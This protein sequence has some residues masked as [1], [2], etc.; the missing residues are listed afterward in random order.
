MDIF[1]EFYGRI[2]E[3]HTTV[4][5][6]V[7]IIENLIEDLKNHE[8]FKSETNEF[9]RFSDGGDIDTDAGFNDPAPSNSGKISKKYFYQILLF[10]LHIFYL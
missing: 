6:N 10:D 5:P 9:D 3:I 1:H 4:L 7:V 2:E 8:S